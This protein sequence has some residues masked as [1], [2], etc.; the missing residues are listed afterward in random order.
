MLVYLYESAIS[1][2][3]IYL[4]IMHALVDFS[5]V[6]KYSWFNDNNDDE[7]FSWKKMI[8]KKI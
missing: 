7:K 3:L 6:Y 8:F 5:Y 2:I 4:F 1:F